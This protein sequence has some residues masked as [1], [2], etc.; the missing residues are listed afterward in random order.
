MTEVQ[1]QVS[2]GT[3]SVGE[4]TMIVNGVERVF[5]VE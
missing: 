5:D 1:E 2:L 4:Y 3:F